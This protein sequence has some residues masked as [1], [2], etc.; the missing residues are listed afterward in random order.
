VRLS[1]LFAG[2]FVSGLASADLATDRSNF[3]SAWE[4]ARSGNRVAFG[5]LGPGLRD[6][7]LYPYWQYEDYRQRRATVAPAEMAAFLE[8][9]QDWAFA[10][11][12][13]NTWLKTLGEKSRWSELAQYGQ[14]VTQ[15]ELQCYV[16]LAKLRTG[17]LDDLRAEAE[18]LWAAPQSQP[19]ACD[20][21]FAWLQKEHGYSEELVWQRIRLAYEAGN[22]RLSLYLARFL[23]PDSRSWL[24]RWQELN[25]NRYRNLDRAA[26]WPDRAETR[27]ITSVSLER[28]AHHDASEAWRVYQRLDGQF[29]WTPEVRGEVL[30]EMALMAAVELNTEGLEM[31]HAVPVAHRNEQ[32]LQWWA[33][34]AIAQGNWPEVLVAV[35]QMTEKEAGDERWRYWK[36]RA[37][38]A[39]G[40]QDEAA[41]AFRSLATEANYYG[42]LAA[43]RMD[44]P[45]T[46]CP[47]QPGV[48]AEDV[49]ALRAQ[50]DFARALELQAIELDN[51]ARAEWG[52]ATKRMPPERLKVAAAL[53]LEEGW[54]D[55]AIYAL[56]NSGELRFYDWRFPVLWREQIETESKRYQLDPAWVLGVMRSESAMTEAARS[57]AGAL[58]LMQVLPGTARQ[59]SKQHGL[60]YRG[61]SQLL[62][63]AENIRFGT[64][65]LRELLDR[66]RQNPVLVSGAYNAGPH[67]VDRW[68]GS[69]DFDDPQIWVETL[70][71]YETRDYIPRVLAFTTIYNWRLG[72]PVQRLSSRMPAI[73]SGTLPA[74]TTA[75]VVCLTPQ[76][77]GS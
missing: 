13:R 21:L 75:E 5:Q 72:E 43:D 36:A 28:L 26:T 25:S 38:Q 10:D 69:R 15:T 24:E 74:R 39:Q 56:G 76:L 44:E 52:R 22:P 40:A 23:P 49:T 27:L 57:S 29:E 55:R 4:S 3:T 68:L 12:L 42:F 64:V 32:L 65:Y 70:P 41:V 47:V 45:Y 46:I 14:G 30:R 48:S 62:E 9:H 35:G 50:P 33:R 71:Y 58:G 7:I 53:A 2:F 60:A 6:Y 73:E 18:R 20:P 8:A 54:A 31:M 67:V 11:G 77:A 63:G 61:Q 16:A 19:K 37:W 34:L 1:A 51:W 17:Q 59:I 66:F